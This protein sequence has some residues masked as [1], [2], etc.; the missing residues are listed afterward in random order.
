MRRTHNH[1]TA[2]TRS[3]RVNRMALAVV[4]I[5]YISARMLSAQTPDT[6]PIPMY[7]VGDDEFLISGYLATSSPDSVGDLWNFARSLGISTIQPGAT[8]E[9]L[10]TLAT[11]GFREPGRGRIIVRGL[12]PIQDAGMGRE[13]RFYLFDSVQTL[14]YPW[15]FTRLEGGAPYYDSLERGAQGRIY[16]ASNTAPDEM[17]ASGIAFDWAPWQVNRF[18][19]RDYDTTAQNASALV[20][21]YLYRA[22]ANRMAPTFHVAV[23]GAVLPEGRNGRGREPVLRME[24]WYEVPRGRSYVDTSGRT[25]TAESDLTFLYRTLM[26][27]RDSLMPR[28]GREGWR[29][30][31]LPVNLMREQGETFGPLHPANESKR[32]DLRIYWTGTAPLALRSVALRDSIGELLYGNGPASLGYRARIVDAARRVIY[33]PSRHG[34]PRESIIRLMSGIEQHPTEFGGFAAVEELLG[35][36]IREGFA[37][38]ERIA[39]HTEG[40]TS[41]PAVASFHDLTHS[42]AVFTEIGLAS[43]VDTSRQ[44]GAWENEAYQRL[45][46]MPLVRIP[47]LAEHNGGRFQIP[48]LEPAREAVE[49]DYVPVLQVLR[50]GQYYPT[51]PAWPWNI[52]GI[53]NV[54][55]GAEVMRATGRRMIATVFTTSELHL[56]IRERGDP[57]DTLMSHVPEASELRAMINLSLCYGAHGIHYFWLGNYVNHMAP[58][59]VDPDVWVGVNDSWGSNG[60]LTSDTTLDHARSFALTD[61]RPT[62]EFPRGTPRVLI[63]GFYVGYGVR[64]REIRRINGW[65]ARIGP[66]LAKLRWRDGYSMHAA[67]PHP[68]IDAAQVRPRVL[69]P[70]EIVTAVSSRA[71][72]GAADPPHATYVELGFFQPTVTAGGRERDMLRDVHHLYVVNRRCF[73]RPDDIPAGSPLGMRLDSLAE[74]RTIGVRFNL[75]RPGDWRYSFIRVREIEADTARLPL[76]SAPRTPLDTFIVADSAIELTLRPGGGALLEITY[77]MAGRRAGLLRREERLMGDAMAYVAGG[78]PTGKVG[79]GNGTMIRWNPE[80]RTSPDS[81][82]HV[83]FSAPLRAVPPR[84]ATPPAVLPSHDHARRHCSSSTAAY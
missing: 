23:R 78:T 16:D 2:P 56:R 21:W 72:D 39:I 54:G 53:T 1:S 5:A 29:E 77:P 57:L 74:T 30:F 41:E 80:A 68:N 18:P 43:P 9:Q 58:S 38:E 15:K 73:E 48:L 4:A 60:P 14:F 11:S 28:D 37:P 10:D 26:I 46:G 51:G 49:R 13:L 19:S 69:P 59:A 17:I 25:H 12:S 36:N 3:S 79:P 44:F 35:K 65:L 42:D 24:F 64:T 7:G 70:E 76:A 31:S 71:R 61:N 40:G 22:G 8:I 34:A 66:A 20:D 27:P 75:G 84:L 6:A 50:F 81:A 45:F 63:P 55:R 32:I 52:G 47:S 67:V 33:G 62:D 83:A 82:V